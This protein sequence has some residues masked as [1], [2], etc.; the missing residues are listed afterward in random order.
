ML[1]REAAWASAGGISL[2]PKVAS[3]G[4]LPP[5]LPPRP[6]LKGKQQRIFVLEVVFGKT[7]R[8]LMTSIHELRCRRRPPWP[9]VVVLEACAELASQG[10]PVKFQLGGKFGSGLWSRPHFADKET[11]AGGGLEASKD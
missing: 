6:T 9:A 4:L 8:A 5:C 1:A 10:E 3:C 2:V 11:E 7:P